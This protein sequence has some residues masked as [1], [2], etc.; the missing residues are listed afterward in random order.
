MSENEFN[1]LMLRIINNVI[2]E[3]HE[4]HFVYKRI[5]RKLMISKKTNK[6]KL[7]KYILGRLLRESYRIF[8]NAQINATRHCPNQKKSNE[9]GKIVYH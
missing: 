1:E 2:E 5:F 6:L 3:K 9:T 4:K 8:F 7:A